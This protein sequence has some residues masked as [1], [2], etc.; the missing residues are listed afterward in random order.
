MFRNCKKKMCMKLVQLLATPKTEL[1]SSIF[2]HHYETVLKSSTFQKNKKKYQLKS[3]Q[4]FFLLR[5]ANF[6]PLWWCGAAKTSRRHHLHTLLLRPD[7]RRLRTL[8]FIVT[9][10]RV[11]TNVYK[12]M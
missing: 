6:G 7:G 11:H 8:K 2:Q 5:L 10:G 12:F 9:V 1:K 3:L 4:T